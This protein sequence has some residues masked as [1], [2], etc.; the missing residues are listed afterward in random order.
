MY[1][2]E[3]MRWIAW[4]IYFKTNG[5]QW[6]YDVNWSKLLGHCFIWIL[7]VCSQKFLEKTNFFV[8]FPFFSFALPPHH[9]IIKMRSQKKTAWWRID[10]IF[11]FTAF[12]PILF[13]FWIYLNTSCCV[14]LTRLIVSFHSYSA[15]LKWLKTIFKSSDYNSID[16]NRS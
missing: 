13:F 2:K 16:L 5:L 15:H 11:F 1:A 14:E 4:Y 12:D 7:W 3:F 8:F 10:C 9:H 6:K